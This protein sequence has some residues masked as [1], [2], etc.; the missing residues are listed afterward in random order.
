MYNVYKLT[1]NLLFEKYRT[2]SFRRSRNYKNIIELILQGDLR[3]IQNK[4]LRK[5]LNKGPNYKE[6][7]GVD[8]EKGLKYITQGLDDVIDKICSKNKNIKNVMSNW[9][10]NILTKLICKVDAL[11]RNLQHRKRRLPTLEDPDVLVYLRDLQRNSSRLI[12]HQITLPLY[13]QKILCFSNFT[14]NYQ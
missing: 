3:I 10:N 7:R 8:F 6:S 9:K 1:I 4:K 5:L 11:T 14:R 2:K 13:M 12:K